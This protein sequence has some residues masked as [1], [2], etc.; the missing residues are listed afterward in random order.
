MVESFA[1]L[2]SHP[3]WE[4]HWRSSNVLAMGMLRSR[5]P[6]ASTCHKRTSAANNAT[7]RPLL[8]E[9]GA[10]KQPLQLCTEGSTV[11]KAP[12]C[13]GPESFQMQTSGK[14]PSVNLIAW[15]SMGLG[16]L[17]SSETAFK[18][19]QPWQHAASKTVA[20][21]VFRKTGSGMSQPARTSLRGK[22]E[23]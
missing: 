17:G 9:L 14:S 3:P 1:A 15:S 8:P 12:N 2:Q 7:H 10:G 22:P 19:H 5:I 13:T 16:S 11:L 4:A 23:D 18:A 20:R 21:G 6:R